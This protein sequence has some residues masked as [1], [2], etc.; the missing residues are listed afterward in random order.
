[1]LLPIAI[2]SYKFNSNPDE[3]DSTPV[4]KSANF[5]SI[6]Y[7]NTNETDQSADETTQEEVEELEE[8]KNAEQEPSIGKEEQNQPEIEKQEEVPSNEVPGQKVVENSQPSTNE[9][10]KQPESEQKQEKPKERY[11][12]K[13]HKVQADENLYRIS[14]KYYNSRS[15]EELIKRWNNINGDTVVEG[16]VLRI[17]I[18]IN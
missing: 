13:Y 6:S 4:K 2:L 3:L 9:A 14:M 18:K 16:Q 17:P 7:E 10:T 5:E 15:G 8:P 11:D 1:M 12:V